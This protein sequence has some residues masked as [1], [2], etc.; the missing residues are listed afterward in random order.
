M[1]TV[2]TGVLLVIRLSLLLLGLGFLGWLSVSEFVHL[3][4]GNILTPGRLLSSL[5]LVLVTIGAPKV[6]STAIVC[7]S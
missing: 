2:A 1:A 4:F 6:E 7:T 3:K 5:P